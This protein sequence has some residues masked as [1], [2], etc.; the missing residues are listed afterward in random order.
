MG[1]FGGNNDAVRGEV[2]DPKSVMFDKRPGNGNTRD[3]SNPEG[4][5]HAARMA[6]HRAA[7]NDLRGG[8]RD[9]DGV[10]RA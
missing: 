1:I 6:A 2:R 5:R 9:Y 3:E 7:V 8:G 4:A 10:H